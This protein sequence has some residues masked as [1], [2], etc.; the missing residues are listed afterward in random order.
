MLDLNVLPIIV[1]HMGETNT[2]LVTPALRFVGNVL[3]GNDVQTQMC[4]EQ[5]VLYYLEKLMSC[6]N[7]SLV[8]EA[9]WC[10]SNIAAGNEQQIQVGEWGR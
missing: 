5:N 1:Q 3:A 10:M 4:I 2:K 8:R 6:T 7:Q 9:T